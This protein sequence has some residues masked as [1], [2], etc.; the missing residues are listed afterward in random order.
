[1]GRFYVFEFY[2]GTFFVDVCMPPVNII[3]ESV[4][5]K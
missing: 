3:K 2:T 4:T 5:F 1:M